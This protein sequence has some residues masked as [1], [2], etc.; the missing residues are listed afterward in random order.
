MM[1]MALRVEEGGTGLTQWSEE[2]RRQTRFILIM[3][4]YFSCSLLQRLI[5]P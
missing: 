1:T 5:S 3:D 4:Y 2:A